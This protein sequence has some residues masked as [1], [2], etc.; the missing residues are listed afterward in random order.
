[1]A[2][3]RDLSGAA[4]AAMAAVEKRASPGAPV[5]DSARVVLHFHPD[6]DVSGV[7]VLARILSERRYVSQFVTGT[8]NG[9]LTAFPGGDRHEW[10]HRIFAGAYDASNPADRPVYG[11]LRLDMDPYGAAPRFG[12]AY[13]RMRPG[14]LPRTS[15]AYPDSAF[16]PTSFGTI[17]HAGVIDAFLRDTP[18]DLLDH[19]IEA[20]V[21]GRVLAP[22]DIEAVIVDP[23][24]DDD[25]VVTVLERLQVPLERHPGYSV[26]VARLREHPAYRGSDVLAAAAAVAEN[27]LLTPAIIGRARQRR[28]ADPQTLKRVW[29]CVA[30]FG[31]AW[32]TGDAEL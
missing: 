12:S 14:V 22:D 32:P 24:F 26:S 6:A 29:H 19:Y 27:G 2:V 21:H 15:F 31:R 9:G 4:R 25:R 11:A 23:S 3:R 13:L 10:E 16:E 17:D 1:M 30:R 28:L 8:S 18:D 20:H 5:P 7:P